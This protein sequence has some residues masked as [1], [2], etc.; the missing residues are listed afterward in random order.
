[1]SQ[2]VVADLRS[3][4]DLQMAM[5]QV[6]VVKMVKVKI[7]ILPQPN[8]MVRKI[9]NNKPLMKRGTKAPILLDQVFLDMT[10]WIF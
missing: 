3:R 6:V 2:Q 10:T 7:L 8:R 9:L 4:L 5:V 1:M